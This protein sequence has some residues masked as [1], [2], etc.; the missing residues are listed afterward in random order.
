MTS[1]A[2]LIRNSA[3]LLAGTVLSKGLV[4]VSYIALTHQL[5][6][7]EFGRFTTLFVYISFFGLLADAGIE[8]IVIREVGREPDAMANRLGDALCLRAAIILLAIPLAFALYPT[9][10]DESAPIVLLALAS[11][12]LVL[13]NRGASLRSLLE[14]PYRAALRMEVPAL[15]GVLTEAL[16]VAALLATLPRWGVGAAVACQALA[17]LPFA[18]LLL[19]LVKRDVPL[20][21]VPD[22]WGMTRL[23]RASSPLLVALVLNLILTRLDVL[24][25]GR[26]RGAAEV[27][28]YAAP[29]RLVE[30]A[31]LL[32]ILLMTS[33][34]PM[35]AAS[36]GV[37]P[38]RLERLFRGSVR[39]IVAAV[40]P[41]AVVE[42]A[43][44]G[45]IVST[46]FGPE[47]EASA[48]VLPI[49]AI[50]EVLVVVDIV[51]SSR[52][53]ATNLER[54]NL[55]MVLA[56][57]VANVAANVALIPPFGAVG[58]AWATLIAYGVRFGVAFA[59]FDTRDAAVQALTSLLPACGA[60]V[61]AYLVFAY[62]QF[63][64]AILLV[65]AFALYA[66]LLVL[67]RGVSRRE[68]DLLREIPAT[69]ARPIK[70][71]TEPSA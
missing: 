35:F 11:L 22:L 63:Q 39:F 69:L 47:F 6:A 20:R 23:L 36:H 38:R 42:I 59:W 26:M 51:F 12:T 5:G 14:I 48:A 66:V 16:F 21:P 27:G 28:L 57:A 45:P 62:L 46:L 68:W 17:P 41:L 2:L 53:V 30:V 15:L 50:G 56:A 9:V 60:G 52:L 3:V 18:I 64:S 55:L 24:L 10:F 13:S 40:V 19:R 34:Y 29:V 7:A 25:L 32:P 37:S 44:A 61:G 31:A 8:S 4:F 71:P 33:V 1:T 58:A 49:L 70:E 67:F 65:P 43:F 54:R